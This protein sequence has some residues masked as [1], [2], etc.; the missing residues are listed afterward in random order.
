MAATVTMRTSQTAR[1]L[2][3]D[4][5]KADGRSVVQVVDELVRR[6]AD[7][8]LLLELTSDLGAMDGEQLRAYRDEQQVWDDAPLDD[9]PG[10]R[11]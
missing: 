7:R 5:A 9:P 8:R 6:E 10:G 1:D 11:G 3:A 4:F 2:L